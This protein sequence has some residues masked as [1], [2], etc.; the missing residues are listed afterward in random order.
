M[1]SGGRASVSIPFQEPRQ[2]H[3]LV[4]TEVGDTL[5]VVTALGPARGFL[6]PQEFVEFNALVSTHGVVIQPLA[7]DLAAEARPTR[8]SSAARPAS[9]CR[10]RRARAP[11]DAR[12]VR[13]TRRAAA[14]S[15]SIRRPGAS[16]VKRTSATARAHLIA[17]AAAGERGAAHAGAARACPLLSGARSDRRSQGRARRRGVRRARQ[18]RTA[19]RW[20]CARS[21]TSCSGAA[22]T[23]MKDLIHPAVAKRNDIALWRALA[24]AQQG[25]WV[26]ARE[27]FRSLDTTRPRRCRSNCSASRS[28]KRRVRRWRCATS[29]APRA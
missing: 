10:A 2:L 9:R 15:R 1:Q 3:R 28:R 20:C 26:E 22:P 12:A 19:P 18:A 17:A 27:G 13:V 29:A 24:L 8:S 6:K 4:D 11:A 25:K 16:I 5:L 23:R 7:D 14:A 21:P